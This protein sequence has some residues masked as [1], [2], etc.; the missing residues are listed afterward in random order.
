[1]NRKLPLAVLLLVLVLAL[2]LGG[3]GGAG[4]QVSRNI[5]RGIAA[6]DQAINGVDD[7]AKRTGLPVEAIR[8][9]TVSSRIFAFRFRLATFTPRLSPEDSEIVKDGGCFALETVVYYWAVPTD[10]QWDL[11]LVLQ[12]VDLA[13]PDTV[14][15]KRKLL[16]ISSWFQEGG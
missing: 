8:T 3:C 9:P 13:S 15:I 10:R 4:S 12:G 7:I 11:W 16:N 14:V 1:M 5:P 2:S 6:A